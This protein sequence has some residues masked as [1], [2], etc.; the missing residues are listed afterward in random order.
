M[1]SVESD[2]SNGLRQ[3]TAL[4][5]TVA[6]LT[7]I[8]VLEVREHERVAVRVR[9]LHASDVVSGVLAVE[10]RALPRQLAIASKARVS[11]NLCSHFCEGVLRKTQRKRL[12]LH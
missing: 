6:V 1:F 12:H 10:E 7:G 5:Q 9:L 8:E 2:R 4:R 3:T 11:G